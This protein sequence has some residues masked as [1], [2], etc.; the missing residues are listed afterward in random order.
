[1][2]HPTITTRLQPKKTR[3]CGYLTLITVLIVGAIGVAASLAVLSLG[4]GSARGTTTHDNLH[5][6]RNLATACAEEALQA[7]RVQTAFT[8]NGNLSLGTA[9]CT[10]AV[11]SGGGEN[12]TITSEGQAG[13]AFVRLRIQLTSI[14]HELTVSSW[15]EVAN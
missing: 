6:G 9:S 3:E 2:R 4:I 5:E 8:G 10:Y 12:R 7:I 13:D 14:N 1:M 15:Q 11:T